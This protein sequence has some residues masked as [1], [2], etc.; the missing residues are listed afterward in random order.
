LT[1]KKII[2][3]VIEEFTNSLKIKHSK[4]LIEYVKDR[5]GHDYKYSI[6]SYK[7]KST[8]KWKPKLSFRK[9]LSLTINWYL[10]NT[11]WLN[12]CK[13]IY[14]GKRLGN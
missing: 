8:T 2:L 14:N 5:P 1:N 7:I 10:K 4:N 12:Y 6:N 9:G 13:S 3:K 11:Q